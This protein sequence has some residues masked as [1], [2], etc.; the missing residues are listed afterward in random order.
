MQ[1]IERVAKDGLFFSIFER[2]YEFWAAGQSEGDGVEWEMRVFGMDINGFRKLCECK[3]L[4]D[5]FLRIDTHRRRIAYV[6]G[7]SGGG[8]FGS[9]NKVIETKSLRKELSASDDRGEKIRLNKVLNDDSDLGIA[10]DIQEA[11]ENLVEDLEFGIFNTKCLEK[12]YKSES[13]ARTNP[14]KV[15]NTLFKGLN[16]TEVFKNPEMFRLQS[17]YFFTLK[18][19]LMASLATTKQLSP[20]PDLSNLI[21]LNSFY[22]QKNKF[23]P[24]LQP[25]IHSTIILAILKSQPALEVSKILQKLMSS[26]TFLHFPEQLSYIK[27]FFLSILPQKNKKISEAIEKELSSALKTVNNSNYLDIFELLQACYQLNKQK[28]LKSDF[29]F[30]QFLNISGLLEN[31]DPTIRQVTV[32][33][34]WKWKKCGDS[35]TAEGIRALF[36]QIFNQD[37]NLVVKAEIIIGFDGRVHKE[38]SQDAIINVDLKNLPRMIGR[39]NELSKIN[40]GLEEKQFFGLFGEPGTGKTVLSYWYAKVFKQL[41]SII[42]FINSEQPILDLLGLKQVLKIDSKVD[43]F[44]GLIES[45]QNPVVD[46]G[47]LLVFDNC[48]YLNKIEKFLIKNSK[49]HILLVTRTEVWKNSVNLNEIDDEVH[50]IVIQSLCNEKIQEETVLD[51]RKVFN[52]SFL[53]LKLLGAFKYS[54]TQGALESSI[55]LNSVIQPFFTQFLSSLPDHTQFLI[56]ILGY[57]DPFKIKES[58]I[59]Q[60]FIKKFSKSD[61]MQSKSVVINK[62]LITIQES[63]Q[64]TWSINGCIYSLFSD[65]KKSLE[66]QRAFEEIFYSTFLPSQKPE[67]LNELTFHVLSFLYQTDLNTLKIIEI[68]ILVVENLLLIKYEKN[69]ALD[70]LEIIEEN[71]IKLSENNGTETLGIL[72]VVSKLFEKS[73]E[74]Y[75]GLRVLMEYHQEISK[76][77]VEDYENIKYTAELAAKLG[78]TEYADLLY[79]EILEKYSQQVS[80]TPEIIYSNYAK[81]LIQLKNTQKAEKIVKIGLKISK[82]SQ[83]SHLLL[84]TLAT[85]RKSEKNYLKA[86]KS[87][88]KSKNV[89]ELYSKTNSLDYSNTLL[90]LGK[91]HIKLLEYSL[92]QDL[93]LKSLEIS[94]NLLTPSHLDLVHPIA[95]LS[96]IAN[97]TNND[98]L[99]NGLVQEYYKKILQPLNPYFTICT[100]LSELNLSDFYPSPFIYKQSE[101]RLKKGLKLLQALYP[102]PNN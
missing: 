95:E 39:S 24:Y 75:E 52:T 33:C 2:N 14:Q 84:N 71:C 35:N 7:L 85:I 65:L 17:K 22:Q 12:V 77:N 43:D 38:L 58:I 45:L 18:N 1:K 21:S 5:R 99:I 48:D 61:W 73:G 32:N 29:L 67:N 6:N 89:L 11:A 63:S 46:R 98:S 100:D 101:K 27:F 10:D 68:G 91:I 55:S 26:N 4:A 19:Y 96:K 81:L 8:C 42:W 54:V 59:K 34:L 50:N 87:L 69:E 102:D 31:Q 76:L 92:A 16:D 83:N 53:F 57:L 40:K 25:L 13:L 94:S 97:H 23:S 51:Y 72:K 86:Q 78:E 74:D 15:F 93:I 44:Q 88:L 41:Y 60:V 90:D 47:I 36:G 37:D 80:K 66:T 30:S 49:V 70:L 82:Q 79:S 56:E 3:R 64:V 28:L 9:K 62:G 20:I